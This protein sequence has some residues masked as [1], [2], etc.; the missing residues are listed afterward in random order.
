MAQH[1]VYA[2]QLRTNEYAPSYPLFT[3]NRMVRI[4]WDDI[5]EGIRVY[6]YDEDGTLAGEALGG[7]YLPGTGTTIGLKL[8]V[9]GGVNR[10]NPGYSFCEGTTLVNHRI[11]IDVQSRSS[12]FGP[13]D[14]PYVIRTDTPNHWSC[15]IHQC[16]IE[17]DLVATDVTEDS[18]SSDGEITVASTTSAGPPKFTLNPNAVYTD[19]DAFFPDGYPIDPEANSYTFTGLAAATYTVYALDTFN[20]KAQIIVIVPVAQPAYGVRYRLLFEDLKVTSDARV[21]IEQK[22]YVGEITL[23]KMSGSPVVRSWRGETIED[24]FTTLIGYQI[25]IN[26]ISSSDF[27]FLP[28]FTG[29]DREWRVRSYRDDVLNFLGFITPMLYSEPYY[30]P[31]NYPVNIV[32]TD[33]I[34]NLKDLDFTDDFGNLIRQEISILQAICIILRKTDV[35]LNIFEAVNIY[36][37]GMDGTPIN[38]LNPSFESGVLSPFVNIP[39]EQTGFSFQW[40]DGNVADS[41]PG[42]GTWGG[43]PALSQPRPNSI[44]NWPLGDY[45]LEVT[46]YQSG[47]TLGMQAWLYGFDDEAGNGREIFGLIGTFND[48]DPSATITATVNVDVSKRYLGVGFVRNGPDGTHRVTIEDINI[49]ASPNDVELSSSIQQVFVDPNVYMTSGKPWKCDEV[50]NALLIS[51]GARLYQANGYWIVE[52]IEQKSG[53]VNY[54]VFDLNGELQ[55]SG[56]IYSTIDI[57][58]PN[59]AYRVSW[60]DRSAVLSLTPFYNKIEFTIPLTF[61]NNLLRSSFEASDIIDDE[62]GNP[63]ILGWTYDIT[64]GDGVGFGIENLTKDTGVTE[65]NKAAF[66]VDFSDSPA[67][68]EMILISE[69]FDLDKVSDVD[70][71]FSFDVYIRPFFKNVYGFL[72]YSIKIGD[73]YVRP[74]NGFA[75][76]STI[77]LIDGEY[78]RAYIDNTL[79]WQNINQKIVTHRRSRVSGDIE[80]ST[81]EGPVIIKFRISNNILY[82]YDSIASLRAVST[83]EPNPITLQNLT[84]VKVLDDSLLRF[85]TYD[86]SYED[87]EDYPNTVWPND[88]SNVTPSNSSVWKLEKTVEI[89]DNTAWLYGL[90]IDN[91]KLGYD[92]VFPEELVYSTES[93]PDVKLNLSKT[94]THT[95]IA[96][97]PEDIESEPQYNSNFR[98]LVNNWLRFSDGSPTTQWYRGYSDERR[99]LLDILMRMY[100]GQVTSQS[101]KFSGTFDTDVNPSLFNLF[102]EIRLDKKL[103]AMYLAIYDHNNIIEAE[104]LELKT[105]DDGEPPADIYEFTEEFTTEFDA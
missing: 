78:I 3:I 79:S 57:R 33:Q 47:A 32:A 45:D 2:F 43:A 29:S 91:I 87:A 16:D 4:Y 28:L 10:V 25:D 71:I 59:D 99:S 80:T 72:D 90:M 39:T 64:N 27:Q 19:G 60:R 95:D 61:D 38:F 98:R 73:K 50:L 74:G 37:V 35:I 77:D 17:F 70:L 92:M 86:H 44:E 76:T 8:S 93:N 58:I 31:V 101:Y 62:S 30:T 52:S 88:H 65:E 14:F 6:L 23:V 20:C 9:P 46:G 55:S 51:F 54:R 75:S 85:Y 41:D 48:S 68:R 15:D 94:I 102:R 53:T 1:T 81:L 69:S 67:Y 105:G 100:Q 21:D 12:F 83:N 49:T 7:P 18:G 22:G 103:V 11:N 13:Y 63:Q 42:S 5:T 97:Y 82:D 96:L 24:I 40:F 36:A 84:R 34:A 104:L 89:P 66:F 26:L 56:S